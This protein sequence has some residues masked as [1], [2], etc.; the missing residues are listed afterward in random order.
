MN[1]K[2]R[3]IRNFPSVQ[4]VHCNFASSK[5]A[6]IETKNLAVV[7]VVL[8]HNWTSTG[9]VDRWWWCWTSVWMLLPELF[10]KASED[11]EFVSSLPSSVIVRFFFT[12]VCRLP[13][14]ICVNLHAN[15]S[16]ANVLIIA[17]DFHPLNLDSSARLCKN[18]FAYSRRYVPQDNPHPLKCQKL[19]LVRFISVREEPWLLSC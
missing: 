1:R 3:T 12:R 15:N 19:I 18:S 9:D 17:R 16:G 8:E 4:L 11:N 14:F 13:A 5:K 6:K 7:F 10:L 2:L